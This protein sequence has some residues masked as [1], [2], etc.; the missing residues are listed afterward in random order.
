M[1]MWGQP[2]TLLAASVVGVD[3]QGTHPSCIYTPPQM[4]AVRS[5]L[6]PGY[7]YARQPANCNQPQMLL[8]LCKCHI[9]N[10]QP[11]LCKHDCGWRL[12]V[13]GGVAGRAASV[14]INPSPA[15]TP[16]KA[17]L[18]TCFYTRQPPPPWAHVLPYAVSNV[19][20]AEQ[21]C[22]LQVAS[23]MGEGAA[24]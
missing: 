21:Q 3:A 24:A 17:K 23:A 22:L 13:L 15:A 19:S 7:V 16:P 12:P 2:S 14:P 1:L 11:M 20:H 8:G 9:N 5:D 4:K 6:L 10:Q 18:L